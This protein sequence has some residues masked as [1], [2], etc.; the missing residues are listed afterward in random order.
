MKTT[1]PD[2]AR[3]YRTARFG[4]DALAMQTNLPTGPIHIVYLHHTYNVYH[5]RSEPLFL[6]YA[7]EDHCPQS[8]IGHWFENALTGFQQ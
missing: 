1:S 2:Q 4:N 8:F 7:G 6:C 5:S 3:L